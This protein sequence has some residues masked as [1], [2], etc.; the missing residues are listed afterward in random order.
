VAL[1]TAAGPGEEGAGEGLKHDDVVGKVEGT[2]GI[3]N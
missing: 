2:D 3:S 1:T